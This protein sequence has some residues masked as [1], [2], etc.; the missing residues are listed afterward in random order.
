[1][2]VGEEEH[3]RPIEERVGEPAGAGRDAWAER[4]ERGA[5]ATGQLARHG[6]HDTG[7]RLLVAEDEGQPLSLRRLQ[8]IEV[9]ATTRD[10]EETRHAGSAQGLDHTIGDGGHQRRAGRITVALPGTV[11]PF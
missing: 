11:T 8:Q 9:G 3:G 10:A 4:G 5:R 6:R 2:P 1:M 7:R